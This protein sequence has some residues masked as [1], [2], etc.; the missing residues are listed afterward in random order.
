MS[1]TEGNRT[2]SKD[3]NKTLQDK[4]H[5]HIVARTVRLHNVVRPRELALDV[6]LWTMPFEIVHKCKIRL[7]GT[8]HRGKQHHRLQLRTKQDHLSSNKAGN[9]FRIRMLVLLSSSSRTEMHKGG[10]IDNSSKGG[11]TILIVSM[12]MLRAM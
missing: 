5:V 10:R 2:R 11:H 4:V 9:K 6:G 7:I 12:P 1:R 8:S 3:K